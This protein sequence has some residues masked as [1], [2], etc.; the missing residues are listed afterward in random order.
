MQ[1]PTDS[2]PDPRALRRIRALSW[3]LLVLISIALGLAILIVPL[4]FVALAGLPRFGSLHTF[5]TFGGM[6]VGVVFGEMSLQRVPGV[7]LVEG[8]TTGQR[9]LLAA[10]ALACNACNILA[11]LQLRGL[12]A[13]YSRGVV[14]SMSNVA[15]I[16]AFGLWV[17]LTAIVVNVAGRVFVRVLNEPVQ[18]IANAALAV[19]IG[20]MIYVI[21]YV[22]ELAREADLE[23]QEFV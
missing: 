7:I 19:I 12:F 2:V 23:R 17:A 10:I 21:G 16:K 3:P 6:G 18:G 5:V 1:T 9:W 13:L 11:L 20:A 14:L 15:R 8:L 4:T 22:M